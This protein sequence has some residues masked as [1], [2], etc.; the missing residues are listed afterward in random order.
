[1]IHRLRLSHLSRQQLAY[2]SDCSSLGCCASQRDIFHR[3]APQQDCYDRNMDNE[4]LARSLSFTHQLPLISSSYLQKLATQ[5]TV[6]TDLSDY[7]TSS[8]QLD[9]VGVKV[10]CVQQVSLIDLDANG[11]LKFPIIRMY[12]NFQDIA[13]DKLSC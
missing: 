11:S 3:T 13:T 2:S 6:T 1:M 9:Q 5:S 10:V 8:D 12:H 7:I 4:A